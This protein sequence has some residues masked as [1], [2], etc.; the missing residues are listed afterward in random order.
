MIDANVALGFDVT[1]WL[2][3]EAGV[4]RRVAGFE[5]RHLRL[6]PEPGL[7]ERQ[8][9]LLGTGEDRARS[10]AGV[11][12]RGGVPDGGPGGDGS[13][14]PARAPGPH[15][16]QGL[17]AAGSDAGDPGRRRRDGDPAAR[18]PGPGRR[19]DRRGLRARSGRAVQGI[20]AQPRNHGLRQGVQQARDGD[21]GPRRGGEVGVS[22]ASSRSRRSS[23]SSPRSAGSSRRAAT[24]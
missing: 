14:S 4:R 20:S 23:T 2:T 8:G 21:L 5:L 18:R 17:P 11:A 24:G 1:R 7:P 15:P 12:P 13:G 16:D 10:R 6:R 19:H 9:R 22:S 3:L